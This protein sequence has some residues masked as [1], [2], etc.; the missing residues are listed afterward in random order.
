MNDNT[1]PL[2]F[3]ELP[4]F[5]PGCEWKSMPRSDEKLTG[6]LRAAIS[7][8]VTFTCIMSRRTVTIGDSHWVSY[9]LYLFQKIWI[10]K[11]MYVLQTL[12]FLISFSLISTCFS[13]LWSAETHIIVTHYSPH[14]REYVCVYRATN[15][16]IVDGLK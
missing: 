9:I 4:H 15:E 7:L 10:M 12:S 1:W 8:Y 3:P 11:C 13:R 2:T 5:L 6:A 14:V 16:T